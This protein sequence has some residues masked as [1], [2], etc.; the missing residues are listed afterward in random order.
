MTDLSDFEMFEV[1]QLTT[2]DFKTI[3]IVKM[4]FR[5]IDSTKCILNIDC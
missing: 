2:A 3:S 4:Q 5:Y 1:Q